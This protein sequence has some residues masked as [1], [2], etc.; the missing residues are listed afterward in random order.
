MKLEEILDNLRAEELRDLCKIFRERIPGG[1]IKMHM[2]K[3]L[4][5]II[6][7]R[8]EKF[9]E[10]LDA[11]ERLLLAEIAHT[12]TLPSASSFR[13]KYGM[14][15][16]LAVDYWSRRRK[17]PSLIQCL[18]FVDTR[19][20][21]TSICEEAAAFRDLIGTPPAPKVNSIPEPPEECAGRK[22]EI[23]EGE[24]TT[25]LELGRVLR[26]VQTGKIKVTGK[27]G[28]PTDASVRLI[29]QSLMGEDLDLAAPE[30]ENRHWPYKE[31]PGP[32]RA[33]AWGV[34]VVQCGWAK[35]RAGSLKLTKE[36]ISMLTEPSAESFAG[37]I[38]SLLSDGAFDE[39]NRVNFIR[40]QTG[41]AKRWMT[42]PGDRREAAAGAV[43][44]LPVGEWVSFGEAFRFAQAHGAILAVGG[45]N[46]LYICDSHYG[47][48]Y[49][50]DDLA[51][52]YCRAVLM[53]TF[54]TLGLVDIAYV[55]P[56]GLWPEFSE[57]Y[58]RDA[59]EYLGRYD[60]LQAIRL[61]SLG[62]FCL[63]ASP[64][65]E[66]V[67]AREQPALQ[68]LANL[69]I[70]LLAPPSPGTISLLELLAVRKTEALWKLDAATVLRSVEAGSTWSALREMLAT[71]SKQGLPPNVE[72]WFADLEAKAGRCRAAAEAVLYEWGDEAEALTLAHAAGTGAHCHHAGGNRLVVP[73]KN[74]AA[75]TRAARKRGYLLPPAS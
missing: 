41:K 6:R 31:I 50:G 42:D 18:V 35:A 13:A 59:H 29:G 73:R 58:G 48:I 36:G 60:G 45:G 55:A 49:D 75:F 23:S 5:G 26:L 57:S 68:V 25:F 24:Q 47:H 8:R 44:L 37:G 15:T 69:E 66:M 19:Y 70:P 21:E 40:G 28:R 39:L 38:V 11:A 10:A 22:V 20:G 9:V 56:H 12:H 30:D 74:L 16:P 46:S 51:I 61:T 54:A 3:H 17:T 1:T 7:L 64:D 2:V 53:E 62:A 27:S 14:T 63:G 65:Y 52:Q 67:P 43:A 32:V 34:L 33:H 71:A 4:A 72:E